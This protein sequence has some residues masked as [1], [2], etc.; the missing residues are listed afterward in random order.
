MT[1]IQII[2][3]SIESWGALL[4]LVSVFSVIITRHFDKK[5][6]WKLI[7]LMMTSVL[8]MLSDSLA[9][10]YRGSQSEFGYMIVRGANFCAFFF[11]FL[12][13][14]LAAEYITH[15]ISKRSGIHGLRWKYIEWALFIIETVCLIV[16]IFKPYI[17]DFDNQNVY[18]RLTFSFIP[19]M[20]FLWAWS[21]R[22]AFC[23][24]T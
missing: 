7:A 13:I 17:Y 22:S 16:N 24:G 4:S 3:F 2:H 11:G 8:L 21:S 9:W 15:I 10:I 12:I 20:I 1:L 6:V 14:P 23:S 5:G 19:G 18:F